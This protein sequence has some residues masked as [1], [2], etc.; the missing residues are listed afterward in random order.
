M[1][2]ELRNINWEPLYLCTNV[3]TAWSFYKDKLTNIFNKHAPVFDK[4]VKGRLCPWMTTDIRVLMT[5]RGK[6]LRYAR[7]TNK[8]CDWTAYKKL[9]NKCTNAVNMVKFNSNKK[10]LEENSDKPRKFWQTI[11]NIMPCKSKGTVLK[12]TLMFKNLTYY[13]ISFQ[14][15]Q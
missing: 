3:N 6:A 9:R 1:C 2:E 14:T 13:A 10:L 5:D 8:A 11:K 4:R 15:L 12:L 7:K